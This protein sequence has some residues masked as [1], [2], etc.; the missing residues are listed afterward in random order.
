MRVS[1]LLPVCL[2]ALA[3][4]AAGC[5]NSHNPGYFPYEL[6]GGHIKQMHAKPRFGFF[7]DFDP[8]ANRLEVTP[9][10]ATAPLGAQIVL[11][12][13][14][15]DKDGE[16]RRS[17]RV[18]WILEGPG[19]IIEVDE[20]G[21]Y[22]GRGY[23]VDNKYGV[24]YTG[25]VSHTITRGN[26]D[27]KDD[28]ELC[29][30]QTFC[31]VSSAVP[32]E[33][34][35]TAYAPGVFNW[36]KG[37]VVS[38]IVWGEGRFNFPQPAVIR[39]GGEAVLSTTLTTSEQNSAT[40]SSFKVRYKLLDGDSVP[41]T[42]QTAGGSGTSL[43]QAGI[44]SKE[45]ETTLDPGGAA[46][47]KLVQPTPRT[48]KTRVAVEVVKPAENGVGPGTVVSRRET[49]VEWAAPDVKLDVAA[50]QAAGLSGIVP[51][52]VILANTGPVDARESRVRITLTDGAT[53]EKSEPPPNRQENGAL[54]FD[55]PALAAGKKQEIALSIRPAK[56]GSFTVNADVAT[57]DGLQG[58]KESMTRI[59]T[60]KLGLHIEAPP[61][62]LAG[63]KVPVKI[64]VT[65]SGA[66][67]GNNVTVWAR[68]DDGLKHAS[69]QNPV[70]LAAGSIAPGQ[71]RIVELPLAAKGPGKYSVRATATADGNVTA[72]ADPATFEVR[73]AE[74]RASVTGP[75]LAYIDQDFAWT[76]AVTNA[77]DSAIGNVL[78]RASLPSEVKLRDAGDGKPGA[79]SVEW[80]LPSLKAGEQK[81]LKLAV[82][83]AQ[84][85][86]KATLSVVVTAD[87]T[88]TGD[89]PPV[90]DPV[91][92][93]AESSLA[94]I[95]TPA[96]SL[97]LVAPTGL[98]EV[99][100]RVTFQVRVKNKG[101]ISARNIEVTAFAPAELKPVRAAG[102]AN[103]RIDM[104]G[105]I[106][107]PRLEELRPGET[108]TYTIEA[109]AVQVGDGRLR[110]EVKA[111]EL[112]SAL[113]EE[114]PA[115]VVG[116]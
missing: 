34:T 25:Y 78:V 103:G 76:I 113:K 49:T 22:A 44:S 90:G 50:P 99:G 112:T 98:V 57:A 13:T 81:V 62:A 66:T 111:A 110:A 40:P 83:A 32:G 80:K 79:G 67:P 104:N 107:F 37:R 92:T 14:V 38:K 94:I 54:V 35:I 74:L 2:V 61:A 97:E 43:S 60:G 3:A 31:V 33:T 39:Y 10:D 29:P 53:L 18:E 68:F 73:R 16:P 114:Q 70:E 108:A 86:E 24:T 41:A 48:G 11:V 51:A 58:H 47:V 4:A 19:N 5:F 15:Y 46:T 17:R 106:A 20:A 36:E 82:D 12:A 21:L 105:T 56:L 52:T 45:A 55:L 85:S 42:F 28:V 63:E 95:G 26:D 116:K 9:R 100:K 96:L 69:G 8:K 88:G 101:T 84:L 115:R 27:P 91:Q 59:E 1:L 7:R 89:G 75:K 102:Q 65:N 6:P 77:G 109:D 64:A 93:R 72:A 71:T 87:A 23:K 30:G